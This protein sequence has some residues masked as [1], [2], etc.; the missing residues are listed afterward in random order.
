MDVKQLH[1]VFDCIAVKRPQIDTVQVD[2]AVRRLAP[3]SLGNRLQL[4]ERVHL[5]A[6]LITATIASWQ[7]RRIVAR[8]HD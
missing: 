8:C 5:R 4:G 1:I 6:E 2:D 3:F 7:L